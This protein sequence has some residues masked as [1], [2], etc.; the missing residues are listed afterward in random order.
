[1]ILIAL[2]SNLS[3]AWGSPLATL[4]HAVMELAKTPGTRVLRQ[5]RYYETEGVGPGRPGVFVNSVISI[6]A[7]CGP[8]T[9]LCR[10]KGL[11]RR[12]GPRSA[13]RWGP[14][15]LDLDIL[16]YRRRILGWPVK[17]RLNDTV[18]RNTLV[19][20]HPLLHERLFVLVP[21]MDAAPEWRH[22]VLHRTAGELWSR[23]RHERKGRVINEV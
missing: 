23:M 21:L 16:D 6:E 9:L 4:E 2:G 13:R 1:M 14:R 7:H 11:E 15:T 20:P 19:L 12:A 18:I 17:G 22:P 5:S 8:D 3:G 10:L